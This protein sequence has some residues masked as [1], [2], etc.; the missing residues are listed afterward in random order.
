[1]PLNLSEMVKTVATPVGG[2][3]SSNS[4]GT[5]LKHLFGA[6]FLHKVTWG[7][8]CREHMIGLPNKQRYKCKAGTVGN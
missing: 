8:R 2:S 1:M 3:Y 5:L 4:Y 7:G 6:S